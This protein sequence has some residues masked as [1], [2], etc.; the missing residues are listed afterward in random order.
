MNNIKITSMKI[1]LFTLLERFGLT[2]FVSGLFMNVTKLLKLSNWNTFLTWILSIGGVV[3]LLMKIY[4]QYL[5]TRK[6]RKLQ[7]RNSIL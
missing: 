1:T 7:G 6:E 5:I 4:H 2:A 3:Y